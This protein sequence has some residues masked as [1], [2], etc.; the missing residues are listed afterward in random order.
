VHVHVERKPCGYSLGVSGA[1]SVEPCEI[2][3][4]EEVWE[5]FSAKE[6]LINEL[7]YVLTLVPPL[8]LKHPTVWYST[9]EPRFFDFYNAC[10]EAAIPNMVDPIGHEES[11]EI[12][13]RFRLIGRHFLGSSRSGEIPALEAWNP[14]RV[15]L[16]FS[17][18][19]DSLLSLATL[20]ALGYEVVL[21]NIDERVLPR[22]TAI[23]NDLQ[24]QL[25]EEL[26]FLC[27]SVRNEIQLL[28]DYEVLERP[29]TLLHQVHI[30]FVYLLAMMPFCTH[31]RAPFIVLNNEY[32]NTL[33]QVHREGYL[34]AHKV[35]QSRTMTRKM[36]RMAEK[37]S[38]GQITAVNLIGPLGNF[39]IHRILHEAF[40]DYAKYRISCHMEVSEYSRWCHNC[41]T[42]AQPFVYFLATGRDPFEMGFEASM[43]DEDKKVHYSLFKESIHP[44]D[45]YHRFVREE[46]SLA[47]VMAHR[48]GAEGP[49]M[50]RFRSGVLAG[51]EK[52][53]DKLAKKVFRLQTRSGPT[54]VER[55]AASL[56]QRLLKA[57]HS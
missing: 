3:F 9:A 49:L 35:M 41:Y 22:G 7:T 45:A 1:W 23:R 25:A 51:V 4:P 24:K 30:Y 37:F 11:E 36:A 43:L 52:R 8:I 40:P 38:G 12:F 32:H 13:S 26:G 44:K 20:D 33:N 6:A 29:Q 53:L 39:A 17:F 48:R 31:Y 10:F 18:G 16:P 21:V 2:R 42:C 54:P 19:K 56:Y 15:V 50:D 28:S 55:E 47:F 46:E 34:L 27:H 14:R 5:T 57:Y